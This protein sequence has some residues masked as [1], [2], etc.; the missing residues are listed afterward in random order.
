MEELACFE[1]HGKLPD[2]DSLHPR[3]SRCED[4]RVP[5]TSFSVCL[6]NP[7]RFVAVRPVRCSGQLVHV[8]YCR[9][10]SSVQCDAMRRGNYHSPAQS[11]RY[12]WHVDKEQAKADKQAS[13]RLGHQVHSYSHYISSSGVFFVSKGSS[14]YHCRRGERCATSSMMP[15]QYQRMESSQRHRNFKYSYSS[16]NRLLSLP[17]FPPF[18]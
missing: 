13:T 1:V 3:L 11:E 6:N 12:N 5:G 4:F 2:G 10:L 17:I 7:L 15:G 8:V 9:L 18:P 14:A 16:R